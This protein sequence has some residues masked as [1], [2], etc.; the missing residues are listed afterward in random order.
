VITTT[1]S[2]RTSRFTTAHTNNPYRCCF[3]NPAGSYHSTTQFDTI[4]QEPTDFLCDAFGAWGARSYAPNPPSKITIEHPYISFSHHPFATKVPLF[5][6]AGNGE[7]LF[8]DICELYE[9]MQGVEGNVVTLELT[10]GDA[11]HDVL[12]VG[13]KVGFEVEAEDMVA[14]AG[15]WIGEVAR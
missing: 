8:G 14:K 10:E 2:S 5:F 15:R 9:E 3:V 4:P 7:V 11:P 6:Q 1:T 12:Y 13:D